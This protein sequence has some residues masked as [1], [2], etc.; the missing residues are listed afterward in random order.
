MYRKRIDICTKRRS[1]LFGRISMCAQ[2]IAVHVLTN[3][4]AFVKRLKD[5]LN[6]TFFSCANFASVLVNRLPRIYKTNMETYFCKTQF[7]FDLMLIYVMRVFHY[8]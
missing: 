2:Y 1:C 6:C 5:V 4:P 3:R 8:E 7:S